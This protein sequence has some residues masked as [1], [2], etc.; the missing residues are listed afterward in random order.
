MQD[1]CAFFGVEQ[2][3]EL[4]WA[5]CVNTR[6]I[7]D[8]TCADEE[9][10]IAEGDIYF[11]PISKLPYLAQRE[12]DIEGLAFATWLTLLT[13]AGKGVKLDFKHP[14]AVEVCLEIIAELDPPTPVILHAEVFNLLG[15][16]QTSENRREGFEPEMFVH[17]TQEHYPAATISLGWS[18]KREADADGRMEE[19]LIEQMTD[20]MFNRLGGL[21]YTVELRGGY[22]PGWDRGAAFIFEPIAGVDR[23][24]FGE[25]VIDGITHFRSSTFKAA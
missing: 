7:L 15:E 23:P 20:L 2:Q 4:T 22:T 11:D 9:V 17:M 18:L 24:N 8:I 5:H 19:I 1:I 6:E 21:A 13:L 10:M 25:N 14:A 16:T 12:D 3:T